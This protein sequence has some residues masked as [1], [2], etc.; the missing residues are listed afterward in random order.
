MTIPKTQKAVFF[1]ENGDLDVI[2]YDDIPV[3]EIGEGDVLIKNKY[4]G[5]NYIETYFRTGLY[6]TEKPHILGREATGEIVKVGSKVNNLKVG[7]KVGYL[8]TATFAQYTRFPATG[9]ILRLPSDATDENLKLVAGA[10]LQ[11]LTALTFIYEAYNVQKDDYILVTA[12]A[13]GVGLLLCQLLSKLKKAHVIAYASTDEKLKLAQ[14]AGAEFL[15]NSSTTTYEEQVKKILDI[16]GGKGVA[17][18]FDSVGRDTA[19]LSLAV[20]GRKGTF[21]SFG[22]ASG[23][24]PPL[25]LGRLSA[26]NLKVVRPVLYGYITEHEEFEKYTNQLFHLIDSGELKIYISR[27]YPL[28]KYIDAAREFEGRKTTGKLVFEIPQ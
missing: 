8:S 5:L 2:K 21:V 18:S 16:T 23:P 13:G 17:A 26:K 10:L 20:I 19:D 3:P 6:P 11:G 24:V 27:V 25:Q 1:E 4:A 28:E 14:E 15:V 7:D 12:A 9:N 22:N